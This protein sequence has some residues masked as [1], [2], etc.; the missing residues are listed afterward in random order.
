MKNQ[1]REESARPILERV[2]W[3]ARDINGRFNPES[4]LD[5]QDWFLKEGFITTR[6]PIQKLIT[7]EYSDYIAKQLGAF[8][9]ENK[10]SKLRGCQ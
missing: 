7:S 4:V 9:V 2:P 3:Q 8:E 1:A 5:I 6:L 10:D